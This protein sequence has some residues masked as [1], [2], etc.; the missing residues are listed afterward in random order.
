MGCS[1]TIDEH[2]LS[3]GAGSSALSC[4]PGEKQ[5]SVGGEPICAERNDPEYGCARATCTPCIFAHAQASCSQVSGECFIGACIGSYADCDMRE[6]NGCETDL[7]RDVDNC[8]Q[9]GSACREVPHANVACGSA[10]CYILTCDPL[11]ERG[12][13]NARYEDGCEIDLE[14]DALHCGQCGNP[15]ATGESCVSGAC[16]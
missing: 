6:I 15:C 7:N 11:G 9:C 13:C 2:A 14:S 5:C 12:D 10:R 16:G 8:R 3:G 4:S 1:F